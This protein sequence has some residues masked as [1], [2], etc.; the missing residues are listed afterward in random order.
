M[1]KCSNCGE[2]VKPS[3]TWRAKNTVIAT[4]HCP[5]CGAKWRNGNA[6]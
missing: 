2:N 1:A 3:K 6:T 4:Y 5:K